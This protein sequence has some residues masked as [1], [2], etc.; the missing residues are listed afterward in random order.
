MFWQCFAT[1]SPIFY[2]FL[3]SNLSTKIA[4][5]LHFSTNLLIFNKTFVLSQKLISLS[6][7]RPKP[8]DNVHNLVYKSSTR[9]IR[10][11]STWITLVKKAY[12]FYLN[13]V[14]P[15]KIVYFLQ[16]PFCQPLKGRK[17]YLE[18][19]WK[20]LFNFCC[21][22]HQPQGS[23]PCQFSMEVSL[24]ISSSPHRFLRS[25][26]RSHHPPRQSQ[27]GESVSF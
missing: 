20:L 17:K 16:L 13:S 26:P 14:F 4:G 12:I 11:S 24:V 27:S 23:S 10:R 7:F 25:L 5:F 8:V 21:V 6:F 2:I 1:I 19:F 3:N 18:N 9:K 22:H 15:K